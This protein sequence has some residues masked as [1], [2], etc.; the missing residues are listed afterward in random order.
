MIETLLTYL[1]EHPQ[2]DLVYADY[3]DVDETGKPIKYQSV[4]PPE[5]IL[6]DDVIRVCFLMRKEVYEKIGPQNPKHHPVHEVPWRIK[7][8]RYFKISPLHIPLLNYIVREGSLT[9]KIGNRN[10]WWMTSKILLEEGVYDQN[11]YKM[12][13]AQAEMNQAFIEFIDHGDYHAFWKYAFSGIRLNWRYL[14]DRG[15][16]KYLMISF[17][18]QRE[19]FREDKRKELREKSTYVEQ[20]L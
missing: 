2:V 15:I 5:D 13:L 11:M 20:R 4:H 12:S 7:V 14:L 6:F 10:L 3:W 9:G 8:S 17:L 19:I 1:N 16:L 18:P